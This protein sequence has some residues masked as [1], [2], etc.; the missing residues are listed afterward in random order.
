MPP[1]SRSAPD[2]K[3]LIC[4]VLAGC[5]LTPDAGAGATALSHADATLRPARW[6]G[7]GIHRCAGFPPLFDAQ[8]LAEIP[9]SC[10]RS[11][12]LTAHTPRL[13]RWLAKPRP[14]REH[15]RFG[16]KLCRNPLQVPELAAPE[17][18]RVSGGFGP[19]Q[20]RPPHIFFSSTD[21]RGGAL[22]GSSGQ[23]ET[24]SPEDRAQIA[25]YKMCRHNVDNRL[26]HLRACLGLIASS[27]I[28]TDVGEQARTLNRLIGDRAI[29]DRQW[30]ALML[31][32]FDSAQAV[33]MV[34]ADLPSMAD[35]ARYS[36]D[37]WRILLRIV[38]AVDDLFAD[39]PDSLSFN[40]KKT[41]MVLRFILT[42]EP[43]MGRGIDMAEWTKEIFA[44]ESI[45]IMAQPDL[46]AIT[47]DVSALYK[48][49]DNL[50]RNAGD[51][52]AR[53]VTIRIGH[54]DARMIISLS[55]DGEGMSPGNLAKANAVLQNCAP[56]LF[57][58]RKL[59][60]IDPRTPRGMGL[61]IVRQMAQQLNAAI[62]VDSRERRDVLSDA[63]T[64]F[65]ISLPLAPRQG[66]WGKTLGKVSAAAARLTGASQRDRLNGARRSIVNA[67]GIISSDAE[68]W[69][70][71]FRS[72]FRIP[73]NDS[74]RVS[75]SYRE[76]AN[77]ALRSSPLFV[78]AAGISIAA[79]LTLRVISHHM[80]PPVNVDTSEK[81]VAIPLLTIHT[82]RL[83][84]INH[85]TWKT[86]GQ[87]ASE[88]H[89]SWFIIPNILYFVGIA[90]GVAIMGHLAQKIK[91]T[92]EPAWLREYENHEINMC[93]ILAKGFL[94]LISGGLLS[95]LALVMMY[96]F[97]WG[98]DY[99][100]YKFGGSG[101]LFNLAD[102]LIS[103]SFLYMGVTITFNNIL[104]II[105]IKALKR[106]DPHAGSSGMATTPYHDPHT[107]AAA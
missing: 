64:T 91:S 58:T 22:P 60:M 88:V 3:R 96:R 56:E 29:L 49:L 9:L 90:V 41:I 26:S 86:A 53:H 18:V 66:L 99:F 4:L 24:V 39:Y 34:P 83:F 54:L 87:I 71:A 40:I 62:T 48:L 37:L 8:A 21:E 101:V 75:A 51:A 13:G 94:L 33:G 81:I 79:D 73:E 95:I 98:A 32:K 2:I 107:A 97:G 59:G 31:A 1:A 92:G 42:Q 17:G 100:A 74:T 67:A 30:V 38:D 35:L 69:R 68:C 15:L 52:N 78:A 50:V 82:F 76:R 5:L 103:F 106:A 70:R 85:M 44:S 105:R 65:T 16:W 11:R 45:S 57:S 6:G 7:I 20:V 102:L 72:G 10:E 80:L 47:V 12:F 89:I 19:P 46:P 36:R 25:Q 55:D 43:M 14:S 77:R 61:R 23:E 84:F 27:P 63:G 28:N 104:R 93:A